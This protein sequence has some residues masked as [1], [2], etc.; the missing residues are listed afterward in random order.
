MSKKVSN[1]TDIK[2]KGDK[3][4]AEPMTVSN[5]LDKAKAKVSKTADKVKAKFVVADASFKDVDEAIE[6]AHTH[7]HACLLA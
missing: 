6:E 2:V 5:F 3:Y 4:V 7:L 1:A